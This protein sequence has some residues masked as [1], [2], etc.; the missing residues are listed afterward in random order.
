MRQAEID[1]HK[2]GGTGSFGGRIVQAVSLKGMYQKKA[3]KKR[4]ETALFAEHSSSDFRRAAC[5]VG[6][7]EIHSAARHDGRDGVFVDHLCHRVTQQ[8]DV[9]VK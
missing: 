5:A 6:G 3:E 4:A 7:V 8:H 9:L 1:P 2:N